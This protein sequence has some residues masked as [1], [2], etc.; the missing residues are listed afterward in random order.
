MTSY[1][2]SKLED[3]AKDIRL[4]NLLPGRQDDNIRL[5]ISHTP[6]VKPPTQ[7][8]QRMS[9]QKIRETL[10]SGWSAYETTEGQYLF[11]HDETDHTSWAHPLTHIDP[12]SYELPPEVESSEF[13]PNY[14]ALSYTWG[15]KANSEIAYIESED[16]ESS[17]LQIQENLASALRH[18][19]YENK[20]RTLFVDAICIN[21]E[22]IPERNNQVTRMADIYTLA[23]RVVVWL[24]PTSNNSKLGISTLEYLGA[25]VESMKDNW[26]CHSPNATHPTWYHPSCRLPYDQEA[27]NAIY[28]LINRPWFGRLWIVQEIHLA[29]HRATIQCGYDE[30]SWPRFRRALI[31]VLEKTELPSQEFSDKAVKLNRLMEYFP[32]SNFDSLIYLS[33]HQLC[34]DPRDKVYGLLGLASPKIAAT[35]RPQYSSPVGTVYRDIFLLLLDQIQR[36][37]SLRYAKWQEELEEQFS[38]WIPDWSNLEVESTAY[39]NLP[40]AASLSRAHA[41]FVSP[42]LLQ[43]TGIFCA[44]VSFVCDPVGQQAAHISEA[45]QRWAPDNLQTGSYVTGESLLDAFASTLTENELRDRY[46]TIGSYPTLQEVKSDI[47]GDMTKTEDLSNGETWNRNILRRLS[48]RAFITTEEGYFGLGT[49][50]TKPGTISRRNNLAES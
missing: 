25:Q 16:T 50:S 34:V 8:A 17:T 37:D 48:S 30:I 19:R 47:F 33:T 5:T 20:P 29:N 36:L 38:S 24:G 28:D 18:L 40:S 46:A 45:I 11:Q 7:L 12:S 32:E 1:R 2:Y 31:C 41:T 21:Q 35:V 42:N 43:V 39:G 22:D 27:W 10:P 23:H 4:V 49:P 3:E 6:L 26:R 44:T 14:E 15:T 9:L 13:S